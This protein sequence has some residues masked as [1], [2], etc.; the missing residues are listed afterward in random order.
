[1]DSVSAEM[2]HAGSSSEILESDVPRERKMP[3]KEE[4]APPPEQA[5]EPEVPPP[6]EYKFGIADR[7][8]RAVAEHSFAG[9]GG[10][11][12][13]RSPDL[14]PLTKQFEETRKR[15]RQL[16]ATSKRYHASISTLDQDRMKVSLQEHK[17]ASNLWL[18]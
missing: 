17:Q 18:V 5:K 3:A 2:D 13:K 15:L 10:A 6:E 9:F 12:T 7:L 16:I 8:Q 14:V 11:D 4:Q 1:M